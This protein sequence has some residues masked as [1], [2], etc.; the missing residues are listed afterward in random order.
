MI[1]MDTVWSGAL[2]RTR[3]AAA[4]RTPAMIEREGIVAPL[5][6]PRETRRIFI[7]ALMGADPSKVWTYAELAEAAGCEQPAMRRTISDMRMAGHVR[8][9]HIDGPAHRQPYTRVALVRKA[10]P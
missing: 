6:E 9:L 8:L 5:P 2:D 10:Q 7:L 3:I 1:E 4:Q